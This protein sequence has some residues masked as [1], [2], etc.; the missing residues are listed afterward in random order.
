MRLAELTAYNNQKAD[1][2]KVWI[3][4]LLLGWSY[5]SLGKIGTQ[6]L[7]YLTF[8]G[9][10]VWCLIR[11]FTLNGDIKKYN[12]EVAERCNLNGFEMISV[13]LIDL[14]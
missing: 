4:F 8:G 10:G 3:L 5:G 11:F 14:K 7:Y 9:L 2:T 13:G 1:S 12:R 6:I